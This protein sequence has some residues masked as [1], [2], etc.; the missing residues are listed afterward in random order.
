M[1]YGMDVAEAVTAFK[2]GEIPGDAF[3]RLL[4]T[5]N[6]WTAS[7]QGKTL[8]LRPDPDGRTSGSD[9]FAIADDVDGVAI[10]PGTAHA[11]HIAPDEFAAWREISAAVPVERA[12]QRLVEGTERAG[13]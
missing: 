11:I 5:S 12:W 4:V 9:V 7:K 1:L 3:R 8:V 2:A 13:D 10:D 6:N